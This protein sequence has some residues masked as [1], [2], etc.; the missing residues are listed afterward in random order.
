[1]WYC[2]MYFSENREIF[3]Y[4][5]AGMQGYPAESKELPFLESLLSFQELD[6]S[7]INADLKSIIANWDKYM[8]AGDP[9][10]LTDAMVGLG[11]LS[12]R[13]VYFQ[14][15]YRSWYYYISSMKSKEELPIEELR[16]LPEQLTQ[17]R[18]RS[19]LFFERVLDIDT[20]G[21]EPQKQAA[22]NYTHDKPDDEKMFCFRPIPISF[23]PVEPGRCSPVLYSGTISHMVD[24]SLRSCVERE[25]TVRRCKGCG[26][27]FP[28]TGRVS[29][30]YCSRPVRR[31]EST[32]K[33]KG[34]IQQWE[35]LQK[36]DGFF[37]AYR[38][39]YKKRFARTKAGTLTSEAF[40]VWSRMAK[41][42]R[43]EFEKDGYTVAEFEEWLKQS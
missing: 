27:Y 40:R 1:M 10:R 36:G 30:E 17:L 41:G 37:Q 28:Q 23:E 29:A 24:Y 15:L 22:A 42:K 25:I 4:D 26:R 8:E 34:T 7:D 38:R 32:C 2:K 5:A 19:L 9:Q 3:E 33:E 20:A 6:L 43:K 14:L 12:E 13:H 39:E 11:A 18:E 21:R 31:G 35:S 16:Q